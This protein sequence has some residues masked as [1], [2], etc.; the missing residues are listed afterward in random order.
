VKDGSNELPDSDSD[1]EMKFKER[2]RPSFSKVLVENIL[3]N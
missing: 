1:E 2:K 3:M